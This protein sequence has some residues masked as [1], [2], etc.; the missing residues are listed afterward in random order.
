[1]GIHESFGTLWEHL[2]PWYAIASVPQK[3]DLKDCLVLPLIDPHRVRP[4]ALVTILFVF[5]A[6]IV[7]CAT[8][9]VQ[10]MSD[11]RQAIDAAREAG[12]A[13]THQADLARAQAL[14]E[15]AE[16]ALREGLYRDAKRYAIEAKA[17]ATE[18]RRKALEQAP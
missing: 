2:T 16:G 13:S 11:A 5:S 9:P 1:M 15:E 18:A 12:V 6:G 3:S 17:E 7:A 10:E 8:A 14:L 4:F